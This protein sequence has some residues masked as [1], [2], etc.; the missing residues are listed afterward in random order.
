MRIAMETEW[1]AHFSECEGSSCGLCGGQEKSLPQELLGQSPTLMRNCWEQVPNLRRA[2]AVG[3]KDREGSVRGNSQE[4]TES[5]CCVFEHFT[6][7][8]TTGGKGGHLEP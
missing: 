2:G 6:K 1:F 7:S 8:T 5:R 3:T 4:V